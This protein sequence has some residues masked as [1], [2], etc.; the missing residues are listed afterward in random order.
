MGKGRRHGWGDRPC[1]PPCPGGR[2]HPGFPGRIWYTYWTGRGKCIRRAEAE[3]LH[4]QDAFEETED[5]DPGWFHQ[6]CGHQN[7]CA[8]PQG[9][10][11]GDTGH[12]EDRHSPEDFI[13]PGCGQDPGIWQRQD[14]GSG[15]P[16]GAAGKLPDLQG[17]LRITDKGGRRWWKR[18]IRRAWGRPWSVWLRMSWNSISGSACLWHCASW[19]APPRI[20]AAPCSWGTWLTIISYL[21]WTRPV[22]IWPLF[23]GHYWWWRW[24]T[25]RGCSVPGPITSS[26]F[27]CPRERWRSWGTT[28]LAIWSAC[29]SDISTPSPMGISWASIPMT[30]TP[31]GRWSARACPRCCPQ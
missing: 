22:L 30:R 18:E 3:T 11:G 20:S 7:G 10:P 27:M 8:D 25:T 1:L 28:C 23:Y 17:D 29:R 5:I 4:C 6:R 14:G 12:H 24:F 16:W 2:I 21:S 26:W 13:Y 31:C 19:S 15:H 9:V